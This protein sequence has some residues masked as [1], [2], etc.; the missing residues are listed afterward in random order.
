M[1]YLIDEKYLSDFTSVSQ[2]KNAKD[3]RVAFQA[4]TL[5]H[6]KPL[7]GNPLFDLYHVHVESAS[8][9]TDKQA[10]LFDMIKYYM[11]LKVERE[12]LFNLVTISNKGATEEDKAASLE[13][14]TMKRQSIENRASAIKKN[15]LEY[16][17][18]HKSDFPE[19]YPKPTTLSNFSGISF[20]NSLPRYIQ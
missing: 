6:V 5:I 12:M 13:L 2:N 20:D 15:I 9:L 19:Y 11:A 16:L 14:V 7:L 3:I 10:A 18:I 1:S 8:V 17:K 4:V